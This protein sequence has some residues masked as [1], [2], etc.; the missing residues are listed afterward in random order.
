MRILVTGATGFVGSAFVRQARAHGHE[1]GG[2]VRNHAAVTE[3]QGSNLLWFRGTLAEAPWEQIARFRPEALVHL[4]WNITPPDYLE[5]PANHDYLRW[6][7]DFV[8]RAVRTG[9]KQ[10][11]GVGTCIEYR[12]GP[13][14]LREER[15]PLEPASSYA[16]CKHDLHLRLAEEAPGNYRFCW[17][18]PFYVYGSGEHPD[19]LCSRLIAQLARGQK[20]QLRTPASTKDYIHVQDLAA[21]MLL[22][23]ERQVEGT[24]NWG[25]GVG[26]QVRKVAHT[27]SEILCVPHLV[28]ETPNGAP[29]PLAEVVADA[30]RLRGLG[31]TPKI[32]LPQG[33]RE[34][35][36][37]LLP[38]SASAAEFLLNL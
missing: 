37:T 27:V 2:L 14:P 32:S 24:I 11:L 13:E 21:A 10:V 30:T 35:C 19:R 18:R 38:P 7:L 20:A 26:L 15:T 36:Y 4:A 33:L 12:I 29:D 6:S 28:E 1:V 34:L 5:A 25:T 22:T 31:W 16:R 17:G 3:A 8:R 9:V 23:L